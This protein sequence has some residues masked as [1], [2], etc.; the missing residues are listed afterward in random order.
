MQEKKSPLT[1]MFLLLISNSKCSVRC[2]YMH[3]I[4]FSSSCYSSSI[5]M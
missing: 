3:S 4:T 2:K 5:R 1:L